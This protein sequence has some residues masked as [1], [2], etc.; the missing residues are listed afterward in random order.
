MIVY[1]VDNK[2]TR[3]F[4]DKSLNNLEVE[5]DPKYFYRVNRQYILNLQYIK[6]YKMYERV[7]LLIQL[8]IKTIDFTIVVSQEKAR[9]FKKWLSEA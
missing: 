7:K 2:G 1:A 4:I 9:K 6:G 3:Y 5:V 8:N